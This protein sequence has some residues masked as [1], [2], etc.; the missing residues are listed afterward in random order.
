MISDL[1]EFGKWLDENNQDDFGKLV[2]D[3]DRVIIVN[4]ETYLTD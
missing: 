4:Y 3:D 1:I 2:Q